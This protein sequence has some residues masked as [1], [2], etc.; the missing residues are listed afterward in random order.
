MAND[1]KLLI[2]TPDP[3]RGARL[4]CQLAGEGIPENNL[5][6]C[7]SSRQAFE[8][9]TRIEVDAL[10]L[11]PCGVSREEWSLLEKVHHH[12][13]EMTVILLSPEWSL[14]LFTEALR[15]GVQEF[16]SEPRSGWPALLPVIQSARERKKYL[17]GLKGYERL[18]MELLSTASHELRTPLTIV[19]EYVSLVHDGIPGPV[20]SEQ[21]ECLDAALRNCDRLGALINDL[22][23]FSRIESGRLRLR[24]RRTDLRPL[25]ED[26]F[27]DFQVRCQTTQQ[28]LQL[29]VIDPLPLVLCDGNKISQ[30]L[31]NLVG[32]AQKYTSAGGHIWIRAR[33]E[34]DFVRIEIQDDGMGINLRNQTHIFEAFT[35]LE[36]P[37]GPG[38][39][40]TGLGLTISRHI[41]RLHGG[42]I[43]VRSEMGKG[44]CFF[45]TLPL[46]R[47]D[48]EI[49]VFIGDHLKLSR[50]R[51]KPLSMVWIRNR[52]GFPQPRGGQLEC[53]KKVQHAA[54]SVFRD[55]RDESLLAEEEKILFLLLETDRAGSRVLLQRISRALPLGLEGLEQLEFCA[56]EFSNGTSAEMLETMRQGRFISW[57]SEED[58]L[59]RRKVLVIDDET[60]VLMLISESL[61][62]CRIP[63]EVLTTSSGYEGCIRF[64]EFEPDLVILDVNMPKVD[65]RQVLKSMKQGRRF[66]STHFLIVSGHPDCREEMLALG[67]DDFLKKPFT[68][69]EITGRVEE[70]LRQ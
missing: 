53:L 62:H 1:L 18:K 8:L 38:P 59:W 57:M 14:E 34:E 13:H 42:E 30:V 28:S 23:D 12:F 24:R 70:L 66:A 67:G 6:L 60:Q 16:L 10:L 39:K 63:L 3:D 22:L 51:G 37:E 69:A 7:G 44:S 41:V 9:L 54:E 20:T 36:R 26:C 21:T 49:L 43:G 35:Q 56:E 55:Y 15:L 61:R 19:R 31:F 68:V 32:N 27:N 65:G 29:E 17:A 58:A 50:S 33:R 11:A 25:L 46:H 4:K 40:G 48:E 45:F 52:D 2:W 5:T 47:E 64:G